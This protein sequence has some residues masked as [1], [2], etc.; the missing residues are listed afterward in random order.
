MSQHRQYDRHVATGVG[1]MSSEMK[2]QG[3][4]MTSLRQYATVN[5]KC[6]KSSLL[7]YHTSTVYTGEDLRCI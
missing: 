5:G 3:K 2:D 4:T 1:V 7:Q 6:N